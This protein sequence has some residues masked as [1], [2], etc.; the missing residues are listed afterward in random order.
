MSHLF[1]GFG[2]SVCGVLVLGLSGSEGFGF[3][4]GCSF[5]LLGVLVLLDSTSLA[6]FF[7]LRGLSKMIGSRSSSDDTGI[8]LAD[9]VDDERRDVEESLPELEYPFILRDRSDGGVGLGGLG[10]PAKD[11][12]L[13][14]GGFGGGVFLVCVAL[15]IIQY[16]I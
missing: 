9:S 3:S 7:D 12:V 2:G 11:M 16:S 10:F 5:D 14:A 6:V 13:A 4:T 1:T 8:E 15:D